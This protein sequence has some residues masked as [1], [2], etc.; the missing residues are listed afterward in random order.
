CSCAY[1][2][3]DFALAIW[4]A[5]LA[6]S[7]SRTPAYTWSRAATAESRAA[8]ACATEAVNSSADS[9]A[10]TSPARTR[11]PFS[12]FAAAS[13]PPAH[14]AT[15]IS[16]ARTT[17]T[18]GV[19]WPGRH[20]LYA[21]APAATSSSPTAPTRPRLAMHPL[22]IDEKRGYHRERQIAH[23]LASHPAPLLRHLP[24]AGTQLV[25][26]DDAV[27][28]ELRRDDVPRHHHR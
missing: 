7:S 2:S 3:R 17:P 16:V 1:S 6:I 21:P 5:R 28:R 10:T 15:R 20:T 25:H 23:R 9:S 11:L 22:P 8:R 12:T 27:D 19:A 26:A 14:G 24:Q 13:W 18:I 4:A